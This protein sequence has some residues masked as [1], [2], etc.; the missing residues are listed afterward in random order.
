MWKFVRLVVVA[1]TIGGARLCLADDFTLDVAK[2]FDEEAL[3]KYHCGVIGS[4]Y[5]KALSRFLEHDFRVNGAKMGA[6]WVVTVGAKYFES[7]QAEHIPVGGTEVLLHDRT[8]PPGRLAI[9]YIGLSVD[10]K[11]HVLTIKHYAPIPI[12]GKWVCFYSSVTAHAAEK[13]DP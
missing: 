12:D 6:E 10:Q 11:T 5:D 9:D 1:I 3:K 7:G 13:Q 2:P 8:S 4:Q